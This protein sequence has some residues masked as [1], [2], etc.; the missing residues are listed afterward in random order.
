MSKAQLLLEVITLLQ[1]TPLDRFARENFAFDGQKV[2]ARCARTV[3]VESPEGLMCKRA[4]ATALRRY[5]YRFTPP[6]VGIL[7]DLYVAALQ[8]LEP[9]ATGRV[10]ERMCDEQSEEARRDPTAAQ[11]VCDRLSADF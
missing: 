1:G 8:D 6:Q 4:V 9:A 7:A 11:A 10:R 2:F 3:E 5:S